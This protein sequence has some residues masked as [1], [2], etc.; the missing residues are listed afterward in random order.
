MLHL[1]VKVVWFRLQ[2]LTMFRRAMSR[3][4]SI[5]FF[6]SIKHC[7]SCRRNSF[8]TNFIKIGTVLLQLY[9]KQETRRTEVIKIKFARKHL[10]YSTNTTFRL[11]QLSNFM[12]KSSR[13]ETQD[14]TLYV[15]VKNAQKIYFVVSL[16]HY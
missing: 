1:T 12:W 8:T 10:F 16:R 6:D 5:P 2:A 11:N 4:I 7:T 15:L 14:F 3:T 9:A 13:A